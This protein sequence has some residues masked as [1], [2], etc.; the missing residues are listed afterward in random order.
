VLQLHGQTQKGFVM[1]TLKLIQ[2][3]NSLGVIFP[4]K[5]LAELQLKKGDEVYITETPD[6]LR[7]TSLNPEVAEQMRL[8]R[9]ITKER[10]DVLR[11]LAK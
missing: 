11:E 9:G 5:L 7:I 6:G 10:R 1:H 8:A 2:I 4:P 3:G